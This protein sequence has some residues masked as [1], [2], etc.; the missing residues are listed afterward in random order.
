MRRLNRP[1]LALLLSFLV[2]CSVDHGRYAMLSNKPVA[3][4]K[5]TAKKLKE[6]IQGSG[7]SKCE[8]LVVFPVEAPCLLSTAINQAIGSGDLLTDAHVTYEEVNLFPLYKSMQWRVTGTSVE[9][10][11]GQ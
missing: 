1:V 2:G 9:I 8:F 6:G 10:E 7:V 4:E 3:L 5:I 11:N